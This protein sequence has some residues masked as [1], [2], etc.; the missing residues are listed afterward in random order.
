MAQE[1]FLY[2]LFIGAFRSIVQIH[3]Q[4]QQAGITL[5]KPAFLIA[6]FYFHGRELASL[7]EIE[8]HSVL[9]P[10]LKGNV[11]VHVRNELEQRKLVFLVSHEPMES[12]RLHGTLEG[13]KTRLSA[14]S[15]GLIT[16]G[17]SGSR[18]SSVEIPK[19][20]LEAQ[21]AIDYRLI[22]GI[23]QSIYFADMNMDFPGD[24]YSGQ[25]KEKLSL[26]IKQ[27]RWDQVDQLLNEVVGSLKT[28]KASLLAARLICFDIICTV[29]QALDDMKKTSDGFKAGLS[30]VF[31]LKEFETI[32]EMADAIKTV[33]HEVSIWLNKQKEMKRQTLVDRMNAYIEEHY[34]VPDFSVSMMADH[35]EM[36]QAYLSQYYKDQTGLTISDYDTSLKIQRAKRLLTT[37]KLPLRDIALEVGYYNVTSFIRRFK[38]VVGATPGEYR[39]EADGE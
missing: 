7:E 17:V 5:D 10:E 21:A 13:I 4:G 24:L 1:Y 20:Y 34:R 2:K 18:G 8:W 39:K 37:T 31:S 23:G 12:D 3:D 9:E 36:S 30:D 22:R 19:C 15:Q 32:D 29:D 25:Q 11:Q 26:S 27:G 38:Q 16:M 35:F 33:S 14:L 6:A 28:G